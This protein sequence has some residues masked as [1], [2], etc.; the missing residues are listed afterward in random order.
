M[1][2]GPNIS[3]LKVI[4]KGVLVVLILETFIMV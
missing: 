3:P 2:F 4:K 1:D